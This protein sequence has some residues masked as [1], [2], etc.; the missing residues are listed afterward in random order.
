MIRT[1]DISTL[2]KLFSMTDGVVSFAGCR[3]RVVE[4]DVTAWL[5]VGRVRC[6]ESDV[7]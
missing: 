2:D 4:K 5:I 1:S 6:N 3:N 7:I